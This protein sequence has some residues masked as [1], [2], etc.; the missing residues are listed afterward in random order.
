MATIDLYRPYQ[1]KCLIWKSEV[2]PFERHVVRLECCGQKGELSDDHIV[3]LD[4]FMWLVLAPE[5][6]VI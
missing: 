2:L 6:Y 1:Q 4:G 5:P 3:G